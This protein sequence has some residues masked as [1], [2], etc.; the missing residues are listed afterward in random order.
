MSYNQIP[1]RFLDISLDRA[2][3]LASSLELYAYDAYFIECA[4]KYKAPL[5]TLDTGLLEAAK[6]SG[7]Q[8][9]EV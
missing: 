4:R 1:I 9:I 3:E 8:P 6:R 7:I 5:L 2:L